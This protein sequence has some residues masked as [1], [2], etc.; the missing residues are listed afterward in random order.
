MSIKGIPINEEMKQLITQDAW[1]II[2]QKLQPVESELDVFSLVNELPFIS[3]LNEEEETNLNSMLQE[4]KRESTEGPIVAIKPEI[5]DTQSKMFEAVAQDDN[6]IPFRRREWKKGRV[7][8][9]PQTY[10]A[11]KK[12]SPENLAAWKV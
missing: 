5:F 7:M 10:E 12:A 11:I 9:R 2:A 1:K 4:L 8:V 6:L 3:Q